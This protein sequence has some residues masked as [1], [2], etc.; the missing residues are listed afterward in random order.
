MGTIAEN[1]LQ[2]NATKQAI[3]TAI[4]SKGQDLTDVPFTE[5]A[6]KIDAIQGGSSDGFSVARILNARKQGN[7][8]SFFSDVTNLT[9]DEL[10]GIFSQVDSDFAPTQIPQFFTRCSLLTKVPLFDTSNAQNAGELFRGCS[11]LKEVPAFDFSSLTNL[12]AM[13]SSCSELE[14]VPL[15]K[16]TTEKIQTAHYM[17]YDCRKL[18]KIPQFDLRNVTRLDYFSMLCVEI[19]EIWVKNI[20]GNLQV[21]FGT[22]YGH[23]LTVE[24][25]IHLISELRD[26]G[27]AKTFTVG[28][29]NLEK[30]ANVYV[31]PIEITDEM[32]EK[33]DLIDEKLPF[34]VCEST[35]EG[36]IQIV[37]YA[38]LKNWNIA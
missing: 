36:A 23:L 25:L 18:K 20:K 28:S 12:Y 31:R 8:S 15:F 37:E 5:Y 14:E 19:T 4:E 3:K 27:S 10:F 38:K 13:F 6:S 1:L 32:R 9:D 30:L 33:D 35:D 17:F 21:G 2:L 29:A 26:T 34:E 11:K 7:F 16:T 24:S 22:S